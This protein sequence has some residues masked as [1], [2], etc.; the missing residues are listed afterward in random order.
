MD[1]DALMFVAIFVIATTVI[2]AGVVM[3]AF[4]RIGSSGARSRKRK[5]GYRSSQRALKDVM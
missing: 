1:N 4:N 3:V 5:T 2:C